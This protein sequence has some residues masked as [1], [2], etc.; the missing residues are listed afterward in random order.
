MTTW[1]IAAVFAAMMTGNESVAWRCTPRQLAA[2]L[3]RENPFVEA[4]E[5]GKIVA[6]LCGED[7][8]VHI[9][10]SEPEI[11]WYA[12][13]KGATR[14]DIAYPMTLPTRFAAGYQQEALA[15]L[16]REPPA[17]VV[18]AS[19]PLG[20]GGAVEV[21]WGYLQKMERL[22]F[23][24]GYHL[25]WSFVPSAGGWVPGGEWG[26]RERAGATLGVFRR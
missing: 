23:G 8:T 15:V 21:F 6:Q 18:V 10:G 12:R 5:A 11:L 20:F 17:V 16:E 13:R 24:G 14:F 25:D 7:E 3:Y 19:A 4:E 26:E 22:L 2:G 1:M 9:V